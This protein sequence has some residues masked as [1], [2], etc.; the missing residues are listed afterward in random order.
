M[1]SYGLS[2]DRHST[3]GKSSSWIAY[4]RQDP[5]A[6][7]HAP[8]LGEKV[9]TIRVPIKPFAVRVRLLSRR[10][11]HFR[12]YSCLPYLKGFGRARDSRQQL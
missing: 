1:E 12:R 11:R 9:E 4:P 10:E 5:T 6:L 2:Q 3:F 7:L 8:A